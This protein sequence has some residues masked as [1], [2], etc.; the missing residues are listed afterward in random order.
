MNNLNLDKYLNITNEEKIKRGLENFI[1]L[2]P[3]LR[4]ENGE[5]YVGVMITDENDNVWSKDEQ[6]KAEYWV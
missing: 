3:M 5:L 4:V 1:P 6:I 2:Y